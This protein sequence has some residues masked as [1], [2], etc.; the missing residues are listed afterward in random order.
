MEGLE[1][2]HQPRACRLGPAGDIGVEIAFLDAS[3]Q[4]SVMLQIKFL[5]ASTHTLIPNE[6]TVLSTQAKVWY[7]A[8]YPR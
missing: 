8:W 4:K 7:P 6:H 2:G 1:A 3:S 5:V